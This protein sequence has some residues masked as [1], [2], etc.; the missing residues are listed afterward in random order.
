MRGERDS[1]ISLN[2]Y[3]TTKF[4]QTSRA[5]FLLF[6]AMQLLNYCYKLSLLNSK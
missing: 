1:S 6:V 5:S 4:P 3:L 2:A